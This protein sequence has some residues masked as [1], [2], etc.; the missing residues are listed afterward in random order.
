MVNALGRKV[1]E[2][3]RRIGQLQAWLLLTC[4]Y[5]IVVAPVALLFKLTADPL[6]LRKS[7]RSLWNT[8]PQ[9]LDRWAWS[10]AQF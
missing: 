9:P 2:L 3:A 6:H 7:I 4:L 10:R 8:K 1:V 5:F